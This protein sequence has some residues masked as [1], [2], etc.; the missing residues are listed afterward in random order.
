[1]ERSVLDAIHSVLGGSVVSRD[2]Q[3]DALLACLDLA[4]SDDED[5]VS[6]RLILEEHGHDVIG[7]FRS[8]LAV[9]R[10]TALRTQR[11]R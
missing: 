1:M 10:A 2:K 5:A 3:R 11:E 8:A 7:E 4:R 6:L 9:V